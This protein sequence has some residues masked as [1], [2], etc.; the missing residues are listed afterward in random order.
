MRIFRGFSLSV[1]L[2][3]PCV[4]VAQQSSSERL[5]P[6]SF[7]YRSMEIKPD[8][9]PSVTSLH[10]WILGKRAPLPPALEPPKALL[11][12]A[13][14]GDVPARWRL[15]Q[16]YASGE[17]VELNP[18]KAFETFQALADQHAE[19]DPYHRHARFV[20]NAFVS[21]G[22]YL[23]TGIPETSVHQDFDKARRLFEH[24]ASYFRDPE[25][26]YSLASM[27]LTGQ[28]MSTDRRKGYRWLRLAAEKGHTRA[29][30]KLAELL[31]EENN[32][33]SREQA[34]MWMG[35]ANTMSSHEDWVQNRYRETLGK[36]KQGEIE[37][38]EVHKNEW[39]R[40]K[41][42]PRYNVQERF[43]PQP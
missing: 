8:A 12:A 5:P 42:G 35:I 38:A 36:A 23:L 18:L 14:R 32:P 43:D 39:L 37:A 21:T 33:R 40:I 19:I 30:V 10:E 28:G 17:G 3:L 22:H 26:Q 31:M 6:P 4:A 16:M 7:L 11:E 15:A 2:C 25:A 41:Y 24:A 9:L 34:L 1:L 13:S 20:S 29:Q 27:C